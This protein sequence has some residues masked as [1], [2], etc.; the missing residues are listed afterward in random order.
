MAK[1]KPIKIRLRDS[2]KLFIV[3]RLGKLFVCG[4]MWKQ[5]KKFKRLYEIGAERI[6]SELNLVKIMKD[7]RNIKILMKNSLMSKRVKK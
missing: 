2:I 5:E 7:L 4:R 6:E 1:H 3:N